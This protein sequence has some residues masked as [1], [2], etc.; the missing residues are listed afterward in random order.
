MTTTAA[1]AGTARA[2]PLRVTW[3]QPEDLIGHELR[4][5]AEDGRDAAG[6]R[7]AVARG[8]RG[9]GTRPGGRLPRPGR[10]GAAGTRRDP[11]R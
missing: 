11:A 7:A 2:P 9:A 8:G 5:A 3:V 4:Q 10:P 1:V 6:D